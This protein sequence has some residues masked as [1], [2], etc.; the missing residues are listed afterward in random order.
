MNTVSSFGGSWPDFTKQIWQAC[1][2]SWVPSRGCRGVTDE[3]GL[4]TALPK[5][6]PKSF[7]GWLEIPRKLSE[8]NKLPG[9]FIC[10]KNKKKTKKKNRKKKKPTNIAL[11]LKKK[12]NLWK[13]RH[14][15]AEIGTSLSLL[16]FS[17]KN[18]FFLFSSL[19][20]SRPLPPLFLIL[21]WVVKSNR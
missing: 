11:S 19:W 3:G 7:L 15:S 18:G 14:S 6:F 4:V 1:L 12:M 13:I 17:L 2:S 20:F 9:P 16:C 10:K 8:A 5:K 21:V